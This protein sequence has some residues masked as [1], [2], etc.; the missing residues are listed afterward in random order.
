MSFQRLFTYRF[1][2]YPSFLYSESADLWN[3]PESGFCT[4]HI[5]KGIIRRVPLLSVLSAIWHL[6]PAGPF[7]KVISMVC[8]E[9]PT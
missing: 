7:G 1:F 4:L 6:H 5:L 2:L 9:Q 3:F 8:W